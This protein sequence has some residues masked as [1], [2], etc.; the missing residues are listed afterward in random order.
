MVWPETFSQRH[1]VQS[2]MFDE[3]C[4]NR[5]AF[6]TN[7]CN[8]PSGLYLNWLTFWQ[9]TFEDNVHCEKEKTCKRKSHSNVIDLSFFFSSS[10][11][12]SCLE[13][14]LWFAA[15]AFVKFSVCVCVC[16][17]AVQETLYVV[18]G[19]MFPIWSISWC[20]CYFYLV[21]T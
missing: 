9:V 16:V 10:F 11:N 7:W 18:T 6:D 8:G 20:F 17:H 15:S 2:E 4:N 5:R 19:W 3:Q 1:A 13:E 21:Q 14:I 12:S